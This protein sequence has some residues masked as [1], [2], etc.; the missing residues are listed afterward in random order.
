MLFEFTEISHST[1]IQ[2]TR[3]EAL[4]LI[5]VGKRKNESQNTHVLLLDL[6]TCGHRHEL[7]SQSAVTSTMAALHVSTVD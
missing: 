1:I 5:I 7:L 6:N 3:L 2:S 4:L